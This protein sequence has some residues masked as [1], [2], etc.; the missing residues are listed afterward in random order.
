MRITSII[1][2]SGRA[3]A[4]AAVIA[5]Y[6]GMPRLV[7]FSGRT[8]CVRRV[9]RAWSEKKRSWAGVYERVCYLLETNS[10]TTLEVHGIGKQWR[11]ARVMV[12]HV[13]ADCEILTQ[14]AA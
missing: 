5:F 10:D 14:L 2:L 7:N 1:N 6:E 13:E 3:A 9:L 8:Y 12:D 4:H 11:V